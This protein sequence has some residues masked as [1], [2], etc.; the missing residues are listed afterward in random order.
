MEVRCEPRS[1]YSKSGALSHHT[2]T[3]IIIIPPLQIVITNFD[4]V[5]ADHGLSITVRVFENLI[6]PQEDSDGK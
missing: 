3:T 5:F 4:Q 6:K 2:K 1:V